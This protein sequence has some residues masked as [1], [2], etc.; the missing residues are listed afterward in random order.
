[1]NESEQAAQAFVRRL[2]GTDKPAKPAALAGSFAGPSGT[3]ADQVARAL[4][5]ESPRR[6][7]ENARNEDRLVDRVRKTSR[8]PQ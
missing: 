8:S 7:T 4:A 6:T 5:G 2:A 3:R 1:V